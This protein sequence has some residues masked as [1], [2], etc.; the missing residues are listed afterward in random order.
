MKHISKEQKE[1]IIYSYKNGKPVKSISEQTGIPRSTI[2]DWIRAEQPI[3]EEL[4]LNKTTINNLKRTNEKQAAIIEVLQRAF[5]VDSMPT[6]IRLQMLEELYGEYNVH[7]LCDALKVPRGTLYN[8]MLRNKR[9]NTWYAKRREELRV[10]IETVYHENHQIF[11]A[12]KI[13]AVLRERGVKVSEK[14]VRELMADM[15]LIS[16]RERA[17]DY[18]DKEKQ[19]HKNYLNQQFHTTKPNEIWVGD[20]TYF[21]YNQKEYYICVI[22]DLFARKV[23]SY[24]IGLKNSTQ[25]TKATFKAAYESRLPDRSLIF[26]SDNG[27]NYRSKAFVE[28]L[29]KLNVTQSFS[30]P[31]V[32]YDNSVM[33]SFFANMKREELYRTKY[34]SEKDLRQSVARYVQFYNGERPHSKNQYKTPD[35][36]EAEYYC[37]LQN[38][39]DEKSDSQGSE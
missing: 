19:R 18:Y 3:S 9:D 28:Y 7:T 27:S 23:V 38:E 16:I 17:K 34:H 39:Q 2:Y 6:Q 12:K 30:R 21:K 14:T 31:H 33:E 32:P 37:Q 11:G 36:K 10:I 26:H 29:K 25:L 24:K 20:I 1:A 13:A 5:D 4:P 15:G 35:R 8:H 22:I